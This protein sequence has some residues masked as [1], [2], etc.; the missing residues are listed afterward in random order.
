M[1]EFV[2]LR[3]LLVVFKA[4][5]L[6][7]ISQYEIGIHLPIVLMCQWF[8]PTK[9]RI[10]FETQGLGSFTPEQINSYIIRDADGKVIALDLP[11]KF[12]LIANHQVNMRLHCIYRVRTDSFVID[13][14][15]LVVCLVP[16]L[17]PEPSWC[18]PVCLY[19]PEEK[20]SLGPNCGL[21]GHIKILVFSIIIH[22]F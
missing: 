8:A 7:H 2:T 13:I 18:A 14:C 9:L 20:S 5:S 10:T 1:P 15:R 21:G 11:T 22:N 4:S 6:S 19:Y 16:Y 3:V 12:I 17:L